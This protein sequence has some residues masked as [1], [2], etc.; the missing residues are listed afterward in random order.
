MPTVLS[1]KW[2]YILSSI[3][4]V[5]IMAVSLCFVFIKPNKD[6]NEQKKPIIQGE[7]VSNSE[8]NKDK[9]G[10]V[11]LEENSS[12]TMFGGT[13]SGMT[14]TLGG[15]VYVSSGATF[16]M[17]GG[18]ITGCTAEENGGAIYVANGGTCIINDGNISNSKA[19]SENLDNETIGHGG[20][21]YLEDGAT[22]TINN[23]TISNCT[24][25]FGGGA[26]T[27]FGENAT[28]D[29]VNITI[30][31]CSAPAGGGICI[32]DGTAY[33]KG[34]IISNCSAEGGYG[35]GVVIVSYNTDGKAT[36]N[37]SG[38]SINN[39]INSG[40][41]MGPGV[42]NF[43]GSAELKNNT[44]SGIYAVGGTLN[45]TGGTI[46]ENSSFAYGAGLDLRNATN[47]TVTCEISGTTISGNTF[48]S[49]ETQTC[50]GGGIYAAG[51]GTSITMTG[52]SVSN[53]ERGGGLYLSGASFTMHGGLIDSNKTSA[54]GA[55]VYTNSYFKMIG[56]TISNNTATG[57]G[58]GIYSTSTVEFTEMSGEYSPTVSYNKATD[59]GGVY[60]SHIDA[61]GVYIGHNVATRYG[62]GIYAG[63]N[64]NINLVSIAGNKA[65]NGG[66]LFAR[67]YATISSVSIYENEATDSGGAFYVGF[68]NNQ[69]QYG[70]FTITGG[71]IYENSAGNGGAMYARFTTV[72][73]QGGDWGST[74]A[75]SGNSASGSGGAI[76]IT[77]STFTMNNGTI[78][79]NN[80]VN[81]G[82]IYFGSSN[83]ATLSAGTISNNSSTNGG[84]IYVA[85]ANNNEEVQLTGVLINN[86]TATNG[87]G[88]YV[89]K[90]SSDSS[91]MGI[92][93]I[94]D[95]SIMQNT[96]TTNGGGIYNDGKV[97]LEAGFIYSNKATLGGGIY[98]KRT[99]SIKGGSIGILSNDAKYG[100]TATE[101]GGGIYAT[102]SFTMSGGNILYNKATVDGGGVF[103]SSSITMRGGSI[104][105][106]SAT[107]N[108]GGIYSSSSITMS[109]GSINSN[110]AKFGGGLFVINASISGS[111]TKI[112]TNTA[113]ENG[114]GVYCRG[115][116]LN[117]S[118]SSSTG[119][120]ITNNIANKGGGIFAS[121]NNG[122]ISGGSTVDVSNVSINANTAY[123]SGGG[124]LIYLSKLTFGSGACVNENKVQIKSFKT[125]VYGAGITIDD[126]EKSVFSGGEIKENYI[127]SGNC[128]S[129]SGAGLFVSGENTNLYFNSTGPHF[130]NNYI[131]TSIVN[132]AGGNIFINSDIVKFSMQSGRIEGSG[133][134]KKL[135]VMGGGIAIFSEEDDID[136]KINIHGGSISNCYASYG[137]GIAAFGKFV[138]QSSSFGSPSISGCSASSGIGNAMFLSDGMTLSGTASISGSIAIASNESSGRDEADKT[139]YGIEVP[140]R[141]GYIV[142]QGT[143]TNSFDLSFCEY[144]LGL[145]SSFK[146]SYTVT[147]G[148]SYLEKHYM[149]NKAL[150]QTSATSN[151][152]KFTV[153][154][155]YTLNKHSNGYDLVVAYTVKIYHN[156]NS[157]SR[158]DVH[159]DAT[160][161]ETYSVKLTANSVINVT[162][163]TQTIHL[164]FEITYQ[165]DIDGDG[166]VDVTLKS[167]RLKDGTLAHQCGKTSILCTNDDHRYYTAYKAVS[168]TG[169]PATNVYDTA[170]NIM[171]SI[172]DRRSALEYR[173]LTELYITAY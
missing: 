140:Y 131:S 14:S 127:S 171:T 144:S 82:G 27:L 146:I 110:T 32:I 61:L 52:G 7:V 50:Y 69:T 125:A 166:T 65:V 153:P 124:M 19:L 173:V 109:G 141:T 56:G 154:D 38:G 22:C 167:N 44:G 159:E 4:A 132:S 73:I 80:A 66:G 5:V 164:I 48:T 74:S 119:V 13:I 129:A 85:Y 83:I 47:E 39:N 34:G 54:S 68:P 126:S 116:T 18:T 96:A 111:D 100:N 67:H 33:I 89:T 26:I 107:T 117:I 128:Y 123:E 135:A 138:F 17:N 133:T 157:I 43:G 145:N 63:N 77:N 147:A 172:V 36:L 10:Y 168:G 45:L 102:T 29:I 98:S 81:G 62:G 8:V 58:G 57:N 70:K 122:A 24:A 87:A 113:T 1:K 137:G 149:N 88:V 35:G 86:N 99:L 78:R 93:R 169:M 64:A 40:I 94:Y 150:I 103:C 84:G 134:S 3:F 51:S 105:E 75:S 12:Y 152:E 20:A 30:N 158:T 92:V 95:G 60:S 112:Q 76:F 71:L 170:L 6:N 37:I 155:G 21:I 148:A 9:G 2:I 162:G 11:F 55:G 163:V 46:S 91:K 72:D 106:N 59:G 156:T 151:K 160:L 118:G 130:Y 115:G 121:S 139:T 108:G 16:T 53:H 41:Y 25:A 28:L 79:Y 90:N 15:A 142:A 31:E 136:A 42:L 120:Q 104:N 101:S 97:Y 161:V 165:I 114:G 143:L 23:I 49:G